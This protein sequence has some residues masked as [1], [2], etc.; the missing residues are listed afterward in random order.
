MR[1]IQ[2]GERGFR[3]GLHDHG[4]AGRQGRA[5]LA[6]AHGQGKI[7]GG[8]GEAGTHRLVGHHDPA[9]AGGVVA[10]VA[11][12]AH[13]FFG[14]PA[15][16]FSTVAYFGA[17]IGQGPAEFQGLQPGQL[18]PVVENEFES[19]VQNG[20]TLPAWGVRPIGAGP[21]RGGQG[22]ARIGFT[23]RRHPGEPRAVGGVDDGEGVI[24]VT[25]NKFT[26]NE[27]VGGSGGE[28][29]SDVHGDP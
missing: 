15:E 17:A 7:P 11:P 13:G 2:H 22:P 20:A 12:D 1:K 9:G 23:R 6:G 24:G 10:V 8:D 16:E 28:Q 14:E 3:C 29:R 4:A 27:E 25:R 18:L 5:Q 21:D 26:I 19:A